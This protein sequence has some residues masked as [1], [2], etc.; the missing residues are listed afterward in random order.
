MDFL[1]KRDDLL[2]V[3]QSSFGIVERKQTMPVLANV[4]LEL[5]E[6]QLIVIATDTEI[7]AIF[8]ITPDKINSI[9]KINKTTVSAKKLL[10]ICRNMPAD[11]LC[12]FV[13]IQKK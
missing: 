1:V 3:L 10:E 13:L 8:T 4:L 5:K 9:D 2:K 6:N 7:E 11:Q 12:T